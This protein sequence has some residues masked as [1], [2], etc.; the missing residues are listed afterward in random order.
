MLASI[1]V[2]TS[3]RILLVEDDEKLGRQLVE[4]LRG[5]GFEP[6]WVR[7]GREA[8]LIDP[9][10]FCL[11]IVDLM[12]P[13]AHGLDVLAHVRRDSDV[14]VLILTARNETPDKVRALSLGADDYV[15]KPFWPEEL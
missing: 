15:T 5:S 12:L 11:A 3:S 6:T 9:E 13:G 10:P 8:L 4:Y 1:E 14:P 2:G 7:D